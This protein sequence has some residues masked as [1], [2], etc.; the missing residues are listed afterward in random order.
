MDSCL[1]VTLLGSLAAVPTTPPG[2]P[3]VTHFRTQKTATLFAFLAFHAGVPQS[4]EELCERFW[5]ESALDQARMSLRTSLSSLRKDF[6]EAIVADKTNVT[7]QATT[8]LQQFE[9]ATRRAGLPALSEQERVESLRLSVE[10]YDGPLLPGLYDDWIFPERDRLAGA[11]V[12]A[13]CA[14][15]RWHERLGELTRALDY[16]HRAAAAASLNEPIRADLIRL[17]IVAGRPAEARRQFDG[18]EQNL[19]QQLGLEPADSTRALVSDL[20]TACEPASPAI[21]VNL[22]QTRDRFRGRRELLADVVQSLAEAHSS[23]TMRLVTLFGPGGIGKTRL[24]LEVGHRLAVGYGFAEVHFVGLAGA[25]TPEQAWESLAEALGLTVSKPRESVL[26]YLRAHSPCLLILDNLEQLL[27]EGVTLVE[28]LLTATPDV[29][30]LATSR[31]RL[32]VEGEHLVPVGTLPEDDAMALYRDRARSVAPELFSSPSDEASL[33]ELVTELDGLPL[34][35]ELAAAWAGTLTPSEQAQQVRAS[36]LALPEDVRKD[37]RHASMTAAITWST[38][39]LEPALREAF[40]RLSIFQ[41]GWEADA[42]HAICTASRGA[43]AS[44]RDRALLRTESLGPALR[45]SVHRNLQDFG[46]AA[47]TAEER[48]AL[49]ERHQLFFLELAEEKADVGRLHRERENL[50]AAIALSVPPALFRFGL[51]LEEHWVSR[52]ALV[53]AR[54]WYERALEEGNLPA[55]VLLTVGCLAIANNEPTLAESL[56]LQALEQELTNTER[57]RAHY[58]LSQLYHTLTSDFSRARSHGEQA[59]ALQPDHVPSLVTLGLIA[60]KQGALDDAETLLRQAISNAEAQDLAAQA[61]NG[62]GP[63]FHLRAAALEDQGKQVEFERACEQARECYSRALALVASEGQ[64]ALRLKVLINQGSLAGLRHDL[65]GAEQAYSEAVALA[66]TMGD[67]RMLAYAQA[68]LSIVFL[69]SHGNRDEYLRLQRASL[70]IKHRLGIVQDVALAF[71][72]IGR[73][74]APEIAAQLYGAAATLRSQMGEQDLWAVRHA[75]NYEEC[76]SALGETAYDAAFTQGVELPLDQAVELA[77]QA[78]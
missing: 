63:V 26:D 38:E 8:D 19:L 28:S 15:A 4:R 51:A 14:L 18:L 46:R 75:Q 3:P 12:A 56:L 31:H 55:A 34:A 44:L 25:T 16:A 1:Q 20:P 57:V 39:L 24:S 68:N 47:L 27:P 43:L 60:R 9:L 52:G 50:G 32:A 30:V 64:E 7:L 29:V 58:L 61:W 22:P 70:V 13:L 35:L 77:L 40:L 54:H 5:P 72:E 21:V 48:A 65:D 2:L 33:R 23:K 36:R 62:L 17:L 45:F 42:A 66:T 6:G 67:S 37:P 76:R 11:Y 73:Q 74:L 59:L 53:E 69:L 49:G 10:V 41:G 71:I 78:Q